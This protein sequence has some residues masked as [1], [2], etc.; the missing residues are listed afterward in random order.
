MSDSLTIEGI[1]I[2]ISTSTITTSGN[3]I[4]RSNNLNSCQIEI[5]SSLN[6]EASENSEIRLMCNVE[7]S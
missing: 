3:Q 4:F 7:E 1:N 5:Q 6:M 2:Q